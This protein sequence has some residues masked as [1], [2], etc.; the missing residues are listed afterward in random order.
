MVKRAKATSTR[1]INDKN[2]H[3]AGFMVVEKKKALLR[4][5]RGT[6]H[7]TKLPEPLFS[8]GPMEFVVQ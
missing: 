5:M 7:P 4:Q 8:P 3:L 1:R 6:P 2:P